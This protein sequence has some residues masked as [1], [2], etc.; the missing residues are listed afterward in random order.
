MNHLSKA[1][2][3]SGTNLLIPTNAMADAKPITTPQVKEQVA[4]IDKN[5]KKEN[6]PM[7]YTLKPGDTIYMVRAKDSIKTIASRFNVTVQDLRTANQL[8]DNHVAPGKHLII[9]TH[10]ASS[11]P[12]KPSTLKEKN[13]APGDTIYMVRRGDTVEKIAHRFRTTPAAIRLTNLVD[14]GTLVVGE[15]L[16]IPTHM[17]S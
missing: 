6:A 5:I 11:A 16:V 8:H 12:T 15:K 17:R 13:V 9:P 2:V 10:L 3:R 7:S 4:V 14:N 1:S